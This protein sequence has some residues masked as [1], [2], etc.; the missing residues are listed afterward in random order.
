VSER[1]LTYEQA[2]EIRGTRERTGASCA[3]IGY[4]YGVSHQTVWKIIKGL[5]YT[6]P[7]RNYGPH[8]NPQPTPHEQITD[9]DVR[10]II[11]TGRW[12]VTAAQVDQQIAAWWERDARIQAH[13]ALSIAA[14]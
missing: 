7:E 9:A 3:T 13:D 11:S 12:F 2:Q 4:V 8:E 14:D 10:R 5:I 1:N 6:T